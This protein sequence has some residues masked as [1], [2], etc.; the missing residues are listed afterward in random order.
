MLRIATELSLGEL[1]NACCREN[2]GQLEVAVACIQ[3]IRSASA[4]LRSLVC[5]QARDMHNMHLRDIWSPS[6]RRPGTTGAA[7]RRKGT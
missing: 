4:C 5:Q 1:R 2:V 6:E 3:G 7:C